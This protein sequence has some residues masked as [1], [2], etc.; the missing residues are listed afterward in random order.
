MFLSANVLL[1]GTVS[2]EEAT[3]L[4]MECWEVGLSADIREVS[5]RRPIR[6]VGKV[7]WLGLVL[8][9]LTPFLDRIAK[10]LTDSS[11]RHF[12]TLARKIFDRRTQLSKLPQVLVLQDSTTGIQ[13]VLEPDL[14]EQAHQQLFRFDLTTIHRGPLRYDRHHNQ[15]RSEL[16]EQQ[17]PVSGCPG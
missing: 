2:L 8:L 15:W 1:A 3:E 11:Y 7:A 14:P 16:D 5:H 13:V 6:P 9:P 17:K 12:T 4:L 10:D